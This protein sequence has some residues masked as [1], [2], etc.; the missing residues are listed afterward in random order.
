MYVTQ[1]RILPEILP[2]LKLYE[3]SEFVNIFHLFDAFSQ[4]RLLLVE[5]SQAKLK[6]D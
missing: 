2:L 4:P 3:R 1:C 5:L 6:L